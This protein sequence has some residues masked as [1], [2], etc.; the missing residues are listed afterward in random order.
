MALTILIVL[1]ITSVL[2]WWLSGY[3]TRVTGED[4]A[5][6]FRRRA[7]RCGATLVLVALGFAGGFFFIGVTVLIAVVWA[8]CLSE[9]GARGFHSLLDSHDTTE[10]DPG[11]LT[12]DLDRLAALVQQ[13]RNEEAIRLCST[14]LETNRRH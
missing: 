8:G 14:L 13:G 7:L 1:A 3:D 4:N 11:K 5:A 10:F 2:A 6:D 9:I 12:A